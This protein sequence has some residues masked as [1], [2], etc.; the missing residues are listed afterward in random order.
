MITFIYNSSLLY[1]NYPFCHLFKKLLYAFS[2]FGWCFRKYHIMFFT[3]S[4]CH[5]TSDLPLL[6]ID[7]TFIS[8][9]N[10]DEIVFIIVVNHFIDPKMSTL[11][12]LF[13]CQVITYYCS[14]CVS[15]I[16]RYHGTESLWTSSV[17]DV[18]FHLS[19]IWECNRLL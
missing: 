5:C 12:A 4:R 1:F 17:P 14:C 13:I 2:G 11:K 10:H 7:I 3:E 18:Q 16:K 8:C 15:V 6:L 19:A 9:K